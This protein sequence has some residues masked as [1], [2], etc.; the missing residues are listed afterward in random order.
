MPKKT[1]Y[2]ISEAAQHLGISR[3]AVYEAIHA[4]QLRARKGRVVKTV[5]LVSAASLETYQVS[6]S[7]QERAKKN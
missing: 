6:T 3:Q 2:T 4:G 1:H 7:H 5:W